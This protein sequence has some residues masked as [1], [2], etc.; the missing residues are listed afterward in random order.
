MVLIE[1][2]IFFAFLFLFHKLIKFLIFAIEYIFLTIEVECEFKK[3]F[4]EITKDIGSYL[5]YLY[6]KYSRKIDS[7]ELSNKEK[8]ELKSWLKQFIYEELLN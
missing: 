7:L 8:E 6:N 2:L 3:N 1:V 5:D 4:K